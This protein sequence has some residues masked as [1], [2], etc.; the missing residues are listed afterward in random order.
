VENRPSAI[1]AVRSVGSGTPRVLTGRD[2]FGMTEGVRER[3][4]VT[5]SVAFSRTRTMA[6][7]APLVVHVDPPISRK[8]VTDNSVSVP[9]TIGTLASERMRNAISAIP[10]T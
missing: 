6:D 3:H 5:T 8:T 4:A 9:S 7:W 10:S 2:L 1:G